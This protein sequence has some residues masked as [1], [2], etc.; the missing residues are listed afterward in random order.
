MCATISELLS[1]ISTMVHGVL[2]YALIL[3][4]VSTCIDLLSMVLILGSSSEYHGH[5][6]S[7]ILIGLTHLFLNH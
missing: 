5:V 7:Y 2:L 4:G 6:R 3:K 1:D